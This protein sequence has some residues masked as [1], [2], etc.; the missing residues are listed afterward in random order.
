MSLNFPSHYIF[1]DTYHTS[2]TSNPQY[3]QS[4]QLHLNPS[5]A[6]SLSRENTEDT[7]TAPGITVNLQKNPLISASGRKDRKT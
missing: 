6:K 4:K 7:K 1:I 2:L 3:V 5:T